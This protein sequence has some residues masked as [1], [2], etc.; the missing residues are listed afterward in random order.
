[1][2]VDSEGLRVQIPTQPPG[3]KV[4]ARVLGKHR[5]PC[6]MGQPPDAVNIG[7]FTFSKAKWRST[8]QMIGPLLK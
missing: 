7:S 6:P 3:R 5:L 1:M 8:F 4:K 2:P